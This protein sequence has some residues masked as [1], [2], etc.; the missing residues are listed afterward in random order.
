[1]EATF[2][3]AAIT[4]VAPVA[5]GTNYFIT[6]EYLPSGHPLYGAAIRAL[7]AGLLLYCLAR[8]RP[9]GDWWWKSAVLGV[10]NVGAFFALI[11]VASQLLPVSLASTIMS[12]APF[13]MGLFAWAILAERPTISVVIG[14]TAGICGVCLMLGT[15]QTT[16]NVRGVAA[17]LAAVT[18]S[19]FGYALT[20]RWGRPGDLLATT[21]WQLIAGG[22]ALLP[23]AIVFE[24]A[25]PGLDLPA[26]G[27]FAYVTV[28]ATAIAYL[29]WFSGLRH[30]TAASVGLIGLLNP[31]TG[32]LLG[33]SL[34]G[35]RL[36]AR[37]IVGM[38]LILGGILLSR[39]RSRSADQAEPTATV[40][41]TK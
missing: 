18:I 6:H 9:A 19:S 15:A 21:A 35:D 24:G 25:P 23:F 8:R 37:Q 39:R 34:S 22:T 12:T 16:V 14:A 28:V 3:W 26:I 32:V 40:H 10:C 38:A 7:P 31:V 30:L 20:K 29:A 41:S 4:A 17:S 1:M 2:R 11:Y 33:T 36:S 5:W 27:G 13:T